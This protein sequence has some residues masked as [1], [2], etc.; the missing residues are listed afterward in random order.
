MTT[1]EPWHTRVWAPGAGSGVTVLYESGRSRVLR[2]EATG[3][4]GGEVSG[5]SGS[6][7]WKELLGAGAVERMR[8][9]V[10]ILARL[11]GVPGVAGLVET[12]GGGSGFAMVDVG[13]VSLA[14][15]LGASGGDHRGV[16]SGPDAI[17]VVTFALALA[18]VVQGVHRAGVVHKDI[19]PANILVCDGRPILI[20]WDLATTF[21]E[22]RPGFTHPSLIAGTLAYLAPEQTGRTGRGVDQRADMYAL[23]ATLYELVTGRPPFGDGDAM[24]LIHDHLARVPMAACEVNV[25]V[26]AV[27]SDIILRLLE[28][29]PDRRYQ[30]AQGLGA[31]LARLLDALTGDG[32]ASGSD[33][34]F[35]LG[36]GDFPIRICAPSELVGRDAEVAAL[37]S[38]FDDALAD[39]ERGVLVTGAPG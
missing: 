7:I 23:G 21:A 39:R 27:L 5:R 26:P 20:D 25:M 8:H 18:G 34:D 6:V 16:Q 10:A 11:A 37:R 35:P 22:E 3:L 30:S 1:T 17:D 32:P 19:N 12:P 33:V 31:D 24:A 9:E 38:A 14:E 13:G 4:D 15:T 29:E 28:K 36:E 2:L